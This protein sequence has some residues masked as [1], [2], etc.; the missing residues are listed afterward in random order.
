MTLAWRI[1]FSCLQVIKDFK[2]IHSKITLEDLKDYKAIEVKP[3]EAS[4]P[5]VKGYKILTTPPPAGGAALINILNILIGELMC[6]L[7]HEKMPFQ[8]NTFNNGLQRL[9]ASLAMA[10]SIPMVFT[11][12][13]QWL[14]RAALTSVCVEIEKTRSIS[15]SQGLDVSQS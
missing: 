9:D 4:L 3:L 6:F 12:P 15:T 1:I 8:N 13:I 14:T 7:V 11:E 10:N 2:S 5:G